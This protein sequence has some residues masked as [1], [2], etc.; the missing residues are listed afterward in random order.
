MRQQYHFR[1]SA[2]G[3]FAW[4]VNQ[5][6]ADTQHLPIIDVPL[7]DI[8]ELDENY[9]FGELTP[10]GRAIAEHWKLAEAADLEYPILLC[11]DG[12]LMDGMHRVLKA[13]CLGHPTIRAR[14][15]AITPPPDYE[16]VMADDLPYD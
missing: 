14:R 4:N 16:D 12:R 8:A 11:A 10:T 1:P 7:S 3:Y 15:L 6:V 13:Y 5:L 2:N 9:W